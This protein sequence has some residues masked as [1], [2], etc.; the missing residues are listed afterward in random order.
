MF[1]IKFI[2]QKDF[3]KTFSRFSTFVLGVHSKASYLVLSALVSCINFWLHIVESNANS[4]V[5]IYIY[6]AS[7]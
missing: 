2:G 5:N 7:L 1:E 3:D 4:L 6:E